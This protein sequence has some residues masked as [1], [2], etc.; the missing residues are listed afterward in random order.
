MGSGNKNFAY[1]KL[2]KEVYF[3]FGRLQVGKYCKK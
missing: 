3:I 2:Y 1:V